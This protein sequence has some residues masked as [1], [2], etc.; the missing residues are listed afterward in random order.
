MADR[1]AFLNQIQ[2]SLLFEAKV[3]ELAEDLADTLDNIDYYLS[4]EQDPK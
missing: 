1:W 2:E 4:M 3:L